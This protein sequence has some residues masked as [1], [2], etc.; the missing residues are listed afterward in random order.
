MH[1]RSDPKFTRAMLVLYP[2]TTAFGQRGGDVE[3]LLCRHKI[4]IAAL[5]TPTMLVDASSCYAA[6]E[7]MAQTL[8]DVH[9]GAKVAEKSAQTGAPGIRDAAQNAVTLGDFLARIVVEISTQVDNVLYLF[10]ASSVTASFEVKRTLKFTGPTTQLDAIGVVFYVSLIKK[11]LGKTFDPKYVIVTAQSNDGF[12]VDFLPKSSFIKSEINGLR[13]SFPPQWLWQPFS[14][15]WDV[16]EAPRG[17]FLAEGRDCATEE[18]FRSILTDNISR[19]DLSLTRFA[20]I[21]SIHPR[22]IQRILSARGSSYSRMKDDVRKNLALDLVGNTNTPIVSIALQVGLS[23][24]STFNRVFRQWTGKTPTSFRNE[25]RL[26]S[27]S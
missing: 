15:T 11:G 17:E 10:S 14:P 12:P 4:P 19:E 24:S 5:S 26:K 25:A 23:G 9:F 7:D 16:V 18:Y 1:K 6:M 20:E 8:G 3:A 27:Y 22:H 21:C 2:L 13:I